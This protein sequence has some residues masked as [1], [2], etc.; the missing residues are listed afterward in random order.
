MNKAVMGLD[1]FKK[2]DRGKKDPEAGKCGKDQQDS[3][4]VVIIYFACYA[5]RNALLSIAAVCL[6]K[7]LMGMAF[8]V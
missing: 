7:G 4:H 6:L 1:F 8:S 2:I 5:K 3:E